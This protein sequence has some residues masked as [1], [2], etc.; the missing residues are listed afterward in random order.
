MKHNI[1][2]LAL[3][4][5][6]WKSFPIYQIFGTCNSSSCSCSTQIAW[7]TVIMTLCTEHTIDIAI[8]VS[9]QTHIINI[10]S[11]NDVFRHC[12]RLIPETEIIYTVRTF[13]YC[14]ET[15]AVGTLYTDNE[16]I[17]TIPLDSTGIQSSIHH[18]SLH[19]IW[20]TLLVEIISPLQWSVFSCKDRVLI[21]LI[22]TISPLYRFVLAAQQFFMMSTQSFNFVLKSCHILSLFYCFYTLV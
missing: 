17:L 16:Q 15:L 2:L 21:L 19:K 3:S 5:Q 22:N 13:C 4:L 20:I 12:N 7:L 8:F 6:V 11:R 18:D 14:K 9:S 10:G 1:A